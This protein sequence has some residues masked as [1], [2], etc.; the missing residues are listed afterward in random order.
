V[1]GLLRLYA[2]RGN[3]AV[4]GG[5]WLVHT[6]WEW[7]SSPVVGGGLGALPLLK[8]EGMRSGVRPRHRSLMA[9]VVVVGGVVGVER[10]MVVV[11]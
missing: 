3:E 6:W 10:V 9:A 7:R 4:M 11:G 8:G 2:G 5:H 1:G